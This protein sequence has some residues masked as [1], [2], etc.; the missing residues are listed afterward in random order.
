MRSVKTRSLR[1]AAL[2]LAVAV[3]A[4]RAQDPLFMSEDELRR[5]LQQQEIE[6]QR[7]EEARLAE[8]Q[9]RAAQGR[10]IADYVRT[11]QAAAGR[12]RPSD[13]S[14]R[15]LAARRGYSQAAELGSQVA[16]EPQTRETAGYFRRLHL[17]MLQQAAM[18]TREL[19]ELN[20]LLAEGEAG[21]HAAAEAFDDEAALDDALAAQRAAAEKVYQA[22]LDRL[23][24]FRRSRS[25]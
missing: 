8:Q 17:R 24:A 10:W 20:A 15:L 16:L 4:V 21:L 2:L 18:S 19:R 5:A 22:F 11:A 12:E 6:M 23:V 7:E 14:D 25:L 9:R 13:V 3:V 1:F